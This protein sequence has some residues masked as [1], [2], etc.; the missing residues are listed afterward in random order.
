MHRLLLLVALMMA[1]PAAAARNDLNTAQP[2]PAIVEQQQRIREEVLAQRN[3]W[4][5]VPPAKR[6]AVLRDQDELLMLLEG[7]RTIADLK[8]EQQVEVANLLESINAA[9]TGAEDERKI[10]TRERKVGSHFPARVCR[11]VGQIRREREAT[12]LGLE[13]GSDGWRRV[14]PKEPGAL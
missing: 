11:T 7:K 8:P 9:I 4:E 3:G 6:N 10:C 14:P 5:E 12:R 1:N 13:R 2:V